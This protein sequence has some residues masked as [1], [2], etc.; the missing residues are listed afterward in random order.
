[1]GTGKNTKPAEA[2]KLLMK[3]KRRPKKPFDPSKQ[4]DVFKFDGGP[5]ELQKNGEVNGIHYLLDTNYYPLPFK[6][7]KTFPLSWVEKTYMFFYH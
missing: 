5:V 2:Q 7:G 4:T 6:G 3:I 1:M